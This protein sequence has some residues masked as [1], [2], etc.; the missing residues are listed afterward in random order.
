MMNERKESTI[1]VLGAMDEEVRLLGQHLQNK[2]EMKT[3]DYIILKD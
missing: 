2:Q 3:K 1:A